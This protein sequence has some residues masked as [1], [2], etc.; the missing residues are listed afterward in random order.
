MNRIL[1]FVIGVTVLAGC[2]F[3][4]QDEYREYYVVEAYLVA[5]DPLPDIILSK[6]VPI[7]EEYVYSDASVNDASV[8]VRLL[9][10]DST[11]NERYTYGSGG[12]GLYYPTESAAVQ[13]KQLYQLYV[14]LPGGD[15][16][17]AKT[18]VPGDFETVNRQEL[19]DQYRYRGDKQI[20]ITTTRSEY[21]TGRQAYYVFTVNAEKPDSTNLTPFYADLVGEQERSLQN[22]S[23]HSSGI[24]NEGNYSP[25]PEGNITLKVPWLSIA[26]YGHNEVVTNAI[27]DNMYDF[28]RS[29][30]TQTGG[31]SLSPGEIQNI[32][33]NINGG[34]GIFGSMARDKNRFEVLRPPR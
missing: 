31:F 28:L 30:E 21:H 12:E 25:T 27:D 13:E 10:A 26:F 16:I 1:L 20:E 19:P 29:Q 3:Y 34:I 7:E 2:E 18:Y 8:E 15:S 33:Y 11:I 4:E 9:N 17:E 32:R 6:T 24:I 14:T 22:Y 5:Y 23:V